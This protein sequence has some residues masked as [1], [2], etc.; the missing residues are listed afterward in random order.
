MYRFPFLI[1]TYTLDQKLIFL[2][3]L[4]TPI[5]YLIIEYKITRQFQGLYWLYNLLYSTYV[6]MFTDKNTLSINYSLIF[7]RL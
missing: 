5:W 2:Q 1:N 3:E 4:I 6:F 7:R